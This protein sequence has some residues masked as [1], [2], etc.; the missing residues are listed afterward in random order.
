MQLKVRLEVTGKTTVEVVFPIVHLGTVAALRSILIA[1]L[2][3][4]ITYYLFSMLLMQI[5]SD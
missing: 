5:F 4:S 2:S 1:A 3:F